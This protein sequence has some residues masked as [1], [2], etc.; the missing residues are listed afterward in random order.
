MCSLELFFAAGGESGSSNVSA[1]FG[2]SARADARATDRQA[3]V[4]RKYTDV[5][6]NALQGGP[7]GVAQD[8]ATS[9]L[10]LRHNVRRSPIGGRFSLSPWEALEPEK[11]VRSTTRSLELFFA[12]G[13]ESGSSNVSATFVFS[14][15]ADARST[16]SQARVARK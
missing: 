5:L 10:P 14:A 9:S 6:F 1:M 13:G 4:A 3:R 16:D 8:S 11:R 15:R 7:K 12:A 2:S